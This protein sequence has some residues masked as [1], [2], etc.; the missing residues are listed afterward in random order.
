M[1]SMG[2][3]P[4]AGSGLYCRHYR[5]YR[6]SST[7]LYCGQHRG[8]SMG[9]F[10]AAP[11]AALGPY[12]GQHR[13]HTSTVP[14]SR[15][16]RC[17]YSWQHGSH[18]PWA[19]PCPPHGQ[20][21]ALP[22]PVLHVP[23]QGR[24]DPP[25]PRG[26]RS[27]AALQVLRGPRLHLGRLGRAGGAS[28]T[29]ARGHGTGGVGGARFHRRPEHTRGAHPEVRGTAPLLGAPHEKGPQEEGM[30][31]GGQRGNKG[32]LWRDPSV[33]FVGFGGGAVRCPPRP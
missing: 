26:R 5:G 22:S 23:A 3:T 21:R 19:A 11:W 7:G 1:S 18:T 30:G 8:Y 27:R 12:R 24:R 9:S 14:L 6:V 28:P 17:P 25:A 32:V 4:W 31:L 10:G 15:A 33:F 20:H 13:T 2:A 29:P 16:A